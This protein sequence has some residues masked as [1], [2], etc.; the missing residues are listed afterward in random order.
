MKADTN[1]K[2]TDQELAQAS[3]I[4]IRHQTDD[5]PFTVWTAMG[6]GHSI[7]N[8]AVGIIVGLSGGLAFGGPPVF[9]Y[10][11]LLMAVIGFFVA[12]SLGELASAFP[13]SGGQ[14]FWVA[15]LAP[16]SCRRFLSYIVGIVGWASAL[17]VTA[18]VCLVVTVGIFSMVTLANPSFEYKPWMGFVGYQVVNLLAFGFNVFERVLPWVSKTLLF[19]TCTLI[20][21]VIIALLAGRSEKQTAQSFFVDIY[22]ISG[23]PNGVAFFIGLNPLNWSFSCLDAVVH[24][25][26]EI[27]QPRKNIPMALLC[28]VALGTFTG[29]PTV[30]ALLFAATNL[31]AVV[32]SGTPSL[33][34]FYQVYNSNA[35]AIA[36]QSVVTVSAAGAIIGCHTWQS[37]IAWAFSRDKGFPFH[38]H[39]SQI[40]PAPF[41]VPFWAHVWS[42]VWIAILGCLY[43]ASTLAFNSLVAAGILLQYL[44]YS[45]SIAC[46]LWTGR[47][48]ISPG[49]FWYPKLGYVANFVVI[50]WTLIAL[51]FYSFPYY[52]PVAADQ[53]N[54]VSCVLLGVVLYALAYWVL[55]GRK[56]YTMPEPQQYD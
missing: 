39:L 23:W 54:Y 13:H 40:A 21:A 26:D 3:S 52:L 29:L 31:D 25:A 2:S 38:S 56:Q 32:A 7:T 5:K 36:L 15:T 6:I 41:H 9:F 49:P 19:Y 8:T 34:I 46:L 16:P 24:L 44:T 30:F 33:E 48:N 22:N 27:P 11:F 20:L 17:C 10:G 42:S 14:Y 28:T 37:R 1:E 55:F 51:C 53:M 43:L 12:I 47:S 45:A 4:N 50:A 18:S 35:A